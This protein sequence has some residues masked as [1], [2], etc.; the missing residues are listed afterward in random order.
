MSPRKYDDDELDD[1]FADLEQA[2]SIRGLPRTIRG[3]HSRPKKKSA[4]PAPVVKL[5]DADEEKFEYTYKAGELEAG[6]LYDS[7]GRFYEQKWIDDIL[8]AIKG[9]K[10]AS[11]YLCR[12]NATSGEEFL[13]AKVYRPRKFR[14]LRN[15]HLY[16]EG[17]ANVDESGNTITNK[18]MLHAIRKRTDWGREL[19]HTSWLRYEFDTLR[20]LHAAG[21]DV[22]R[23]FAC[24][25]N[26]ILMQYFGDEVMGAP[27]LNDVD[28]DLSEVKPLYQRVLHNIELMLEHNKVHGDL[29]AFNILYW[30]GEIALIDFPQ[31]I[32]P[33]V[34]R[35]AYR[36]FERDV[37]RVCEYFQRYGLRINPRKIAAGFWQK[38]QLQQ[39]PMVDPKIL[40]EDR[41]E[42]RSIWESLKNAR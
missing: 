22:P 1:L 41:D 24:D 18:G 38:Y 27:T 16:R 9:G 17:R 42:E 15:D 40:G 33:E 30:D 26:A 36:I 37:T 12:G 2:G 25:E 3:N 7:L 28:L 32:H 23:P 4:K 21:A 5:T 19:L 13:A 20:I 34:N 31:A 11:V 29:S 39:A 14:Q 10:E 8:R 6:W 35:S